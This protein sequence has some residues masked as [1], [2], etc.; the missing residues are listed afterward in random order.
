MQGCQYNYRMLSTTFLHALGRAHLS[1]SFT[2]PIKQGF[3]NARS[4]RTDQACNR[5]D[6]QIQLYAVANVNIYSKNNEQL[7]IRNLRPRERSFG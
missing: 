1:K 2:N 3:T 6:R 4:T 5:D 7:I